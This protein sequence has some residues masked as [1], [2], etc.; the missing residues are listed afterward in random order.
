MTFFQNEL[1]FQNDF[2]SFSWNEISFTKMNVFCGGWILFTEW[3]FS[4]GNINFFWQINNFIKKKKDKFYLR[5][6][7]VFVKNIHT[8]LWKGNYYSK[9]FATFDQPYL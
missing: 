4:K 3:T 9:R 6:N 2:F 5:E 8:F 1:F 7:A